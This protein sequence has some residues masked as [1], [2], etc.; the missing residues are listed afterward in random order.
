[1]K[2]NLIKSSAFL[3]LALLLGRF[4]GLLREWLISFKLGFSGDTDIAILLLSFPDF[5]TNLLLAGGFNIA[6]IPLLKQYSP[7]VAKMIFLKMLFCVGMLA[8]GIS[9]FLFLFPNLWL[10]FL[11]PGADF[12]IGEIRIP[13][14]IT[15]ISVPFAMMS[16]VFTAYLNANGRFFVSGLGTFIFNFCVIFTLLICF[17]SRYLLVFLSLGILGGSLLRFI[18]QQINQPKITSKDS[19]G[20]IFVDRCFIK[21]FLL[22]SFCSSITIMVPFLARTSCS[23]FGEGQIAIFNYANKFIEIPLSVFITSV[24]IVLYP[25]LCTSGNREKKHHEMIALQKTLLFSFVFLIFGFLFGENVLQAIYQY[26]KCTTGNV[27]ELYYALK[28]LLFLLPFAAIDTI[29]SAQLNANNHIKEVWYSSLIAIIIL[30]G[31]EVFAIKTKTLPMIYLG[32]VVFYLCRCFLL[33]KFG[34]GIVV[35]TRSFIKNIF[36][37]LLTSIF[38]VCLCTQYISS[39]PLKLFIESFFGGFLLIHVYRIDCFKDEKIV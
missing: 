8:S 6:F 1:M 9:L 26:G 11:A 17:N 4:S 33:I 10:L 37:I 7:S 35:F 36:C 39:F 31:L 22:A 15:F 3:S 30:V 34:R 27:K 19:I 18:A 25:L 32:V 16:C 14:L 24:G 12:Q 20:T 21:D 29:F 28:Y 13:L 38:C 2:D 23:F 5:I